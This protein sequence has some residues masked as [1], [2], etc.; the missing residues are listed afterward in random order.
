MNFKLGDEVICIN[1]SKSFGENIFII[2]S[3]IGINVT[4]HQKGSEYITNEDGE[5]Y[6]FPNGKKAYWILEEIIN[7]QLN[8]LKC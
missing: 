7:I 6:R 4:M 5:W 3:I 1:A 8:S 2:D